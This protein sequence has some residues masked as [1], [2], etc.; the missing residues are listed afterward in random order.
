MTQ[1]E[2]LIVSLEETEQRLDK[3]LTQHFPEHS[4]T[5]FQYLIDQGSVLINGMPIKKRTK[6]KVG[7]EIEI[8]FLLTP[9][10]SLV[11]EAIPLDILYEDDHLLVINKPAG[12]VVHPAPG[13]PNGTF[14]N[15]LLHH[16][17]QLQGFSDSL[18]PGIVH[19]LDKDTSGV[20]MAAKTYEMH[21]ALIEC[22]ST[23]KIKKTYLAICLNKP[24]EGTIS[25]S[26]GRHPVNR[27]EMCVSLEGKSAV[28]HLT[29]LAHK[30]PFSLVKLEPI[31]GRTHQLRVHLD[32][33]K[34]PIL[35]DM[36]YGSIPTNRHHDVKRQLLHAYQLNFTH[37]FN[38]KKLSFTAPIPEDMTQWIS[39][40]SQGIPLNL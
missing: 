27:K 12:M 38:Q 17:K 1:I 35:G 3:L 2:N 24:Q 22:F 23:R 11:P 9:E 14:A 6:P 20:L 31:T 30:A 40:I 10:L 7:D 34:C 33:V 36:V 8:C 29:L 13:N 28:T 37:P 19:R 5:Y 15:A 4:R 26:I 16:C 39:T 25:A 32:H 18:R 21:Q